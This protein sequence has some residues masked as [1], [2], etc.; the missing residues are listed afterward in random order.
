M[1]H[2]RLDQKTRS[3]LA[4]LF[5][6]VFLDLLGFG[7]IIPILQLYGKSMHATDVQTGFLLSIYSIMQLFFSPIWGRLSDRAGRRPILLV[8][9]LGS[10]GSQLGFA[11]AP[12][13]FWLVVA[14][15]F[16]G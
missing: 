15:G 10:C 8:S 13:Y 3:P 2:G 12:S 9:I 6:T 5:M 14:R 16:A 11:F 1:L 4:V 7:M